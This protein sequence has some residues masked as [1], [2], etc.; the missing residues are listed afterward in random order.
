M[1]S[2][3]VRIVDFEV[4]FERSEVDAISRKVSAS[5]LARSRV[6]AAAVLA[7]R[8]S[9]VEL[10]LTIHTVDFENLGRLGFF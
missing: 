9:V 6:R 10:E 5:S 1:C 8:I 3:T 2:V 4:N 7:K